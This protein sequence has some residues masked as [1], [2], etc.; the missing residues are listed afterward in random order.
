[1]MNITH[2]QFHQALN[3]LLLLLLGKYT[4]H[5]YLPWTEII[6]LI[7]FSLI[8]EHVLYYIKKGDLSCVSFSSVSTAIGI[9]LMMASAHV[10]IL[11]AVLLLA[12]LQKHFLTFG[13]QHFFNPS[14]FALMMGMLFFYDQSHIVLGQLGDAGWLTALVVLLGIAILVRVD[15]W[16]IPVAYI[17][18]Y[19]LLQYLIVVRSDPILLMEDIWYRFYSVSF[20]VFILFMLTDPRTT[21]RKHWQQMLFG[22]MMAMV[23][24]WLDFN[25]GFRVQHLF[26]PLFVFAPLAVSAALLKKTDRYMTR[27]LVTSTVILVLAVS[28][29]I[30][31]ESQPPYHLEMAV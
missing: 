8:V 16:I 14:N 31:I 24:V 3:L 27:L 4:A 22:V 10:W 9:M 1:M 30:H 20:I 5:I 18:A 21:P 17:V 11:F 28:A 13:D 6:A 25:H 7:V 19:L 29:I 12:L 23:T 15:R 2:P 26:M